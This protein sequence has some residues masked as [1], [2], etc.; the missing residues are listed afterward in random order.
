MRKQ[1]AFA[2]GPKLANPNSNDPRQEARSLVMGLTLRVFRAQP[3]SYARGCELKCLGGLHLPPYCTKVE[4]VSQ[5]D[6]S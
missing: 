2:A 4:A 6:L 1:I 3:L 5:V